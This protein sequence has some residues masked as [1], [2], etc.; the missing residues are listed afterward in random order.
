MA[1]A[2]ERNPLRCS[3]FFPKYTRNH[4]RR[5]K[6]RFFGSRM[7]LNT[8]RIVLIFDG[9]HSHCGHVSI[10]MPTSQFPKGCPSTTW[11]PCSFYF[12]RFLSCYSHLCARSVQP[13]YKAQLRRVSQLSLT[14]YLPRL[15]KEST[16]LG[17]K[18]EFQNATKLRNTQ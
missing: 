1:R 13:G 6:G 16:T 7:S 9:K 8:C 4:S 3:F 18:M 10:I 11:T 2:W 17:R 12:S 15:P 5:R 14:L